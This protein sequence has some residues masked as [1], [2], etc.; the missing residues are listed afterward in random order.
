MDRHGGAS[1]RVATV[2]VAHGGHEWQEVAGRFL[3]RVAP[4]VVQIATDPHRSRERLVG[5]RGPPPCALLPLCPLLQIL[6]SSSARMRRSRQIDAERVRAGWQHR[7][8]PCVPWHACWGP[9]RSCATQIS[10]VVRRV[11][12]C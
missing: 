6:L 7:M 8:C 9:C 12:R 1:Y 10:A 11:P 3:T 2:T 5:T 4:P